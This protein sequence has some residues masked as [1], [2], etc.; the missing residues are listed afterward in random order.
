M[1]ERFVCPECTGLTLVIWDPGQESRE[2]D[3]IHCRRDSVEY[4]VLKDEN[5][6]P[7]MSK[8][9][10]DMEGNPIPVTY[11][12]VRKLGCRYKIEFGKG[13]K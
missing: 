1:E 4:V 12:E 2:I 3:C 13:V 5:G 7:V 6:E 11:G 10:K 9:A 8:G